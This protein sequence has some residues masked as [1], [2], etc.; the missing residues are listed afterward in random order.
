MVNDGRALRGQLMAGL[1]GYS[2]GM[3][4]AR[5]GLLEVGAR[6]RLVACGVPLPEC[7]NRFANP[8]EHFH[9][10]IRPCRDPGW[11]TK[12]YGYDVALRMHQAEEEVG[13]FT[14]F[15]EKLEEYGTPQRYRTLVTRRPWL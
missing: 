10:A 5:P 1:P 15:N 14:V 9:Q 2:S 11:D 6:W 3:A 12:G 8:V 4:E 7:G 13:A